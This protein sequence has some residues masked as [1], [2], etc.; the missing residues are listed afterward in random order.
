VRGNRTGGKT[1]QHGAT[2]ETLTIEGL[3]SKFQK[4]NSNN[5]RI[6]IPSTDI[7]QHHRKAGLPLHV[8][9]EEALKEMGA[10]FTKISNPR[11]E[12]LQKKESHIKM[13]IEEMQKN[14][15]IIQTTV[16]NIADLVEDIIIMNPPNAVVRRKMEREITEALMEPDPSTMKTKIFEDLQHNLQEGISNNMIGQN[17]TMKTKWGAVNN[18]RGQLGEN[19]TAAAVH[20]ALEELQGMSVSGMKTDTFLRGV[21]SKLGIQLTHKNTRDPVTGRLQKSDEVEHDMITTWLEKDE[22]VVNM[23]E[24]KT[25][26]CKPW[27]PADQ[28]RKTQAA[29]T[30][31][32]DAFKQIVKDFVTFKEL[33]PDVLKEDM[34]KIR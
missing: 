18:R 2:T 1:T 9:Q 28:E 14:G 12:R 16:N 17:K 26:E 23:F 4:E 29:I 10:E 22:L 32:K 30:H 5:C 13:Q 27:A 8:T 7:L 21:L 31:A 25:S 33:F 20:R 11:K 6:T 34:K 3:E 24:S 15:Q 19:R